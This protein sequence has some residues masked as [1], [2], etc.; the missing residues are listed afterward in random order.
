MPTQVLKCESEE[1]LVQV[2]LHKKLSRTDGRQ[3]L[4]TGTLLVAGSKGERHMTS[5][6][7]KVKC[8]IICGYD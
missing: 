7:M 6:M 3:I 1:E 8:L 2:L 4:D 5:E